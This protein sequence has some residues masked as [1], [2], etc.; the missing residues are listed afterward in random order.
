MLRCA[1]AFSV[2][3][4]RRRPDV[5]DTV[6]MGVRMR[7]ADPLHDSKPVMCRDTNTYQAI[8]KRRGFFVSILSIV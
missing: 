7:A 2:T 6:A 4:K 1:T 8:D 3:N 5:R